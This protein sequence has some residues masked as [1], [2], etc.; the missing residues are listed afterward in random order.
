M[1]GKP[2]QKKKS[3]S[4]KA[5]KPARRTT[6][7]SAAVNKINKTGK[8]SDVKASPEM[9]RNHK[10]TV[11]TDLFSDPKYLL[12]MYKALHPEDK[13]TS[14]KDISNITIHN[15][16]TNGIYNDL[17]FNVKGSLVLLVEAQSTWSVNIII[18][19]LMYLVET[20]SNIFKDND[21]DLYSSAKAKIPKPELYV[22]YTGKGKK[23]KEISLSEEFFGGADTAVEVKV[24]VISDSDK[25]D[26]ISQYITFTRIAD[27]QVKKHGP[28]AEAVK[29]TIRICKDKNVL[30]KYLKER[31]VEVMDIMTTLFDQDEV[32][33]RYLVNRDKEIAEKEREEERK[34]QITQMLK[35]GR[36]AK[37]IADFCGYPLKLVKSME[38]KLKAAQEAG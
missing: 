37:A 31:E 38:K 33:R 22:I 9:K 19:L 36:S 8:A 2:V 29:E 34:E 27:E 24:K 4:Q 35:K 17:G 11:F 7:K 1:P 23:P 21:T 16:M 18:R 28:T 12:Q 13:R 26:I 5:Q 10:D 30:T 3:V 20:Y 6:G 32:T 14:I 15:V 25:G